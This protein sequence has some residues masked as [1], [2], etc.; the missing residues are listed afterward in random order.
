MIGLIQKRRIANFGDER[1]GSAAH[2]SS[3]AA[4]RFLRLCGLLA[5]AVAVA[6]IALSAA[7]AGVPVQP[8]GVSVYTMSP[9]RIASILAN[10]IGLMGAIT[11][12]RALAIA[13][14]RRRRAILA[15]V[16]GPIGFIIGALV[17]TTA[18]GGIGTGHGLAGG[19]VAMT[20]GLI[21]MALGG[22]AFVRSR[23]TG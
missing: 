1:S 5:A 2:A 8:A 7:P 12:R 9:G 19:L 18:K 14:E 15:L 17:V 3:R 4:R 16:L 13:S 21:G 20:V 22:M 23:R 11:G 10:L 6:G